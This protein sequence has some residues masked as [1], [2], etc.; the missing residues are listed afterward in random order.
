[1]L[2]AAL[3][4]EALERITVEAEIDGSQLRFSA[5]PFS[6]PRLRRAVQETPGEACLDCA[7]C[8]ATR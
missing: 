3:S 7:R 5:G 6:S 4:N 1:L 2:R 8:C